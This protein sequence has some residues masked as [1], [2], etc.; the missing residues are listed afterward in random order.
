MCCLYLDSSNVSFLLRC[1]VPGPQKVPWSLKESLAYGV[2]FGMSQEYLPGREMNPLLC[3]GGLEHVEAIQAAT[4]D[5][6]AHPAVWDGGHRP[7][8][9]V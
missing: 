3:G 1:K 9:L 6:V 5:L 2:S 4:L 8:T 7:R